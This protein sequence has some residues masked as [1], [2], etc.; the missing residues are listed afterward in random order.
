MH[1]IARVA[2]LS[3]K[4]RTRST[5]SCSRAVTFHLL[6]V[7]VT[8]GPAGELFCPPSVCVISSSFLVGGRTMF[9][10]QSRVACLPHTL[11]CAHLTLLTVPHAHFHPY[12]RAGVYDIRTFDAITMGV[13]QIAVAQDFFTEYAP[14][15]VLT[16]HQIKL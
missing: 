14:F 12:P 11:V 7:E 3:R 15:Q 13:P 6:Y 4:C 9:E 8:L 10:C 16:T 2:A 5:W 1:M